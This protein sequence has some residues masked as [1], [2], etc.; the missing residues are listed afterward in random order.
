MVASQIEERL[1]LETVR[2]PS[3][4]Y[5]EVRR[6]MTSGQKRFASNVASQ[7]RPCRDRAVVGWPRAIGS[8]RAWSAALTFLCSHLV[9]S[10]GALAAELRA[11]RAI[12]HLRSLDDD[13]LWDLGIRRKEIEDVVRF[14][15]D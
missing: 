8:A 4:S 7:S 3:D 11:R 10:A 12:N 2:R 13:R 6:Q 9:S 1:A 5:C 15:R 14:G